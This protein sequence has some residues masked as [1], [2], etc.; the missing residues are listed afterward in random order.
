MRTLKLTLVAAFCFGIILISGGFKSITAVLADDQSKQD[1]TADSHTNPT[2]PV[3]TNNNS[4][5]TRG[6]PDDYVGSESCGQCHADQMAFYS[7]SAHR[8]TMGKDF[9]FDRRGCEACHGGARKH[10]ELHLAV[11]K[12]YQ[13]GKSDEAQALYADQGKMAAARLRKFTTISA[14]EVTATCL[15]CHEG[16]QGKS[17]ERFNFRRSEHARHGLSCIDCHSSHS[18]KR[19]EFLLK[20]TQPGICYTCHADQKAS[21]AKMFHHKVPEGGMKCTDCHN[22]HG[23]FQSKQLRS[24]VGDDVTC[25]KCHADKAGPFVYEHAPVKTEGCQACHTPHGSNNPRLLTR[26]EVRFLCLECHSN[27]PGIPAEGTGIGPPT[28]SFHNVATTRFQNCT[29]CHSMIHGSN[30]SRTYFR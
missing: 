24:W 17:E 30:T 27:T 12:L 13:E 19:T 25:L 26:S 6:S 21:F 1:K 3:K 29:V 15:G 18:P 23:G 8:K 9:T 22:Q 7:A 11:A 16:T 5:K 14:A 2:Q 10:T 4:V 20:E 28:P